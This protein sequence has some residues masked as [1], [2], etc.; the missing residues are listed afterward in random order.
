MHYAGSV[1]VGIAFL[2]PAALQFASLRAKTQTS[3]Q[4]EAEEEAQRRGG[5]GGGSAGKQGQAYQRYSARAAEA[6]VDGSSDGSERGLI[7]YGDLAA[8][9]NSRLAFGSVAAFAVLGLIAVIVLSIVDRDG[10]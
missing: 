4:E 10:G 6:A 2:F 8:A 3:Q 7:I 1:G 5:G 9:L